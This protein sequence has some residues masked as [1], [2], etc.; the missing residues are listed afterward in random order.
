MLKTLTLKNFTA[1]AD[2]EFEFC[3]G[4]NVVVG[5]NGT[6]K[7][8]LL[9]AAYLLIRAWPDLMR[10]PRP[11]TRKRAEEYFSQRVMDLFQPITL[12]NLIRQGSPGPCRIAGEVTGILPTV[13][14]LPAAEQEELLAQFPFGCLTEPLHWDLAIQSEQD[15][16]LTATNVKLD[17]AIIPDTA[18]INTNVQKSLF[19]PTKEIVSMFEGLIALFE[20]YEIKLDATYRDL[21]VAMNG[22]ALSQPPRLLVGVLKELE[23]QLG[24]RLE[25]NKGRLIFIGHDGSRTEGPL[26]AEGFAKLATLLFLFHRGIISEKGETLFWDE[27]ESNLN[28]TYI[29]MAVSALV[30]LAKDG[31]Q[32]VI[33]THNLFLLREIEVLCRQSEYRDVSQCYFALSPGK[34][35]IVVSQGKT[36]EEI[37]PLPLLDEDLA[38]SDRFMETIA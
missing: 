28:P 14:G 12:A 9:K 4:L 1:F 23:K 7:T 6:G 15:V 5:Q 8:K 25:L 33:A 27:P 20:R 2:A 21:A 13:S 36:I 3:P 38:Q 29:R 17:A 30:S 35:G 32:V 22:P 26:M 19:L 31:L 18:A 10:N 16:T 24:G 11:L 34:N 37:D